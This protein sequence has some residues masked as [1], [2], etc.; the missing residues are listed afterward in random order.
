LNTNNNIKTTPFGENSFRKIPKSDYTEY[1]YNK[2]GEISVKDINV[3]INGTLK[4]DA[5]GFAKDLDINSLLN[6]N[7]IDQ[8][9]WKKIF[10]ANLNDT[11]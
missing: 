4:L 8:G 7:Y 2:G 6:K 5:N 1:S 11:Y 10:N 9:M 3:N